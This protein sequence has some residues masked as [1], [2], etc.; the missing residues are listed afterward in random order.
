[1]SA[2][3]VYFIAPVGGGPVKI[4]YC[5]CIEDAQR[6]GDLLLGAAR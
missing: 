4:G 5:R 2:S 6:Q 3:E 1:M